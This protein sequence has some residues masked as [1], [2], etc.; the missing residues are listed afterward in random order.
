[1]FRRDAMGLGDVKLLAAAGG[2]IGPGGA[3]MALVLGSLVASLAGVANVARF[4]WISR[5]RARSR[6][7]S[8]SIGRSL[9][10]AR[11]AGRYLPF[12]PYLALGIGIVL[13]A[14]NHVL[15]LIP[16]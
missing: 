12:G 16:V 11:I 6:L 7:S 1:M 9:A 4:F 15:S 13:L 2:F 8:R 3:L 10:S 14:W 5:A